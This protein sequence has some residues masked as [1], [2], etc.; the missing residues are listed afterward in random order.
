MSCQHCDS[1]HHQTENNSL[2]RVSYTNS[3]FPHF[4][5]KGWWSGKNLFAFPSPSFLVE[6]CVGFV[7]SSLSLPR[8]DRLEHGPEQSGSATSPPAAPGSA[9]HR[10]PP[11]LPPAGGT[12]PP[13]GAR[14]PLPGERSPCAPLP[15]NSHPV[16]LGKGIATCRKEGREAAL[17]PTA[18]P[19]GG[20]ASPH[21]SGAEG[22]GRGQGSGQEPHLGAGLRIRVGDSGG[23]GPARPAPRP[24]RAPPGRVP[25][26]RLWLPAGH[27]LPSAWRGPR[28]SPTGRESA[29][30][31]CGWGWRPVTAAGA[32]A[33]QAWVA[34]TLCSCLGSGRPSP[35]SPRWGRGTAPSRA[36]RGSAQWEDSP[37]PWQG[38]EATGRSRSRRARSNEARGRPLLVPSLLLPPPSAPP[39]WTRGGGG[40]AA[41]GAGC[42]F[43][44]PCSTPPLTDA[45]PR[46]S[47]G[48]GKQE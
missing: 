1:Q 23:R 12:F 18:L 40:G 11:P 24:P 17:S 33:D 46:S 2:T 44:A 14:S 5:P 45:L 15:G 42:G 34:A 6:P 39:Y 26:G 21:P 8:C 20:R 10:P 37:T 38:P 13:A 3:T 30:G 25:G 47:A 31:G 32:V 22:A 28:R 7:S 43:R 16:P 4:C 36:E 27:H 19:P 48:G 9:R 29:A 35:H 41:G